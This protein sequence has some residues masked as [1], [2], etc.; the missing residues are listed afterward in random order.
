MND[1]NL[2]GFKQQARPEV[3]MQLITSSWITNLICVA[4][5]LG[6]ADLLSEKP[7][8]CV[9]LAKATETNE[10][11]LYRLLRALASV[12]IFEEIENK[13]FKMTPLASYLQTNHE[14]SMRPLAIMFS[15][16]WHWKPW[17]NIYYSV[18]TGKT[19]FEHVYCLKLFEYLHREPEAAQSFNEAMTVMTKMCNAA[20]LKSY[21]FS[22]N[23]KIV[24]V[25]GGHGSLIASILTANPKIHGILFDLPDVAADAKNIIESENLIDRCTII[26]G[27]FF[28]SVP[29]N[30]DLYILKNVIHDWDDEDAISIL[31]NCHNA[32]MREGEILLIETVIPPANQPSFSKLLDLELVAIAGG[33]ERT[34]VEY[35]TL[36]ELSGFRLADIIAT[37]SYLNIIKGVWVS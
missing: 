17:Q 28:E 2:G 6:I 20:I 33:R 37:S 3:L 35:Q 7:K 5:K 24:E 26:G 13:K 31:R 14:V 27:N 4:A 25:G 21:D 32:M 11:N 36:L 9:E 30:G 19:A 8:S 34:E 22:L 1:F 18:K 16:E 15:E 23:Q 29:S 10:R 12:S